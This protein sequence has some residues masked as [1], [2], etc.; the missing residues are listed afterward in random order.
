[1]KS[2]QPEASTFGAQR[3]LS[4]WVRWLIFFLLTGDRQSIKWIAD[5]PRVGSGKADRTNT[6]ARAARSYKPR[7]GKRLR[8]M[9]Q[10]EPAFRPDR[11]DDV[12][13]SQRW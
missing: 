6:P 1:M 11:S 13:L 9:A 10:P 7:D 2:K 5:R 8:D 12:V 3:C 4:L